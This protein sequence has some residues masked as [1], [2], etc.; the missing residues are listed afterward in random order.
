VTT[1][2]TLVAIA[3]AAFLCATA[4]ADTSRKVDV[5]AGELT[6]ALH[7]LAKQ[8][9]VEFVYSAEQLKGVRTRGVHGE[10]TTEKAVTK[11][12]E[13]TK[14][15]LTVHASGALLISD[16]TTHG[17]AGSLSSSASSASTS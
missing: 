17:S 2:S 3:W 6:I 12:L 7:E 9:G 11:L 1:R 10:Y 14:L 13:G 8:S 16:V 5:P 15:K 4:N